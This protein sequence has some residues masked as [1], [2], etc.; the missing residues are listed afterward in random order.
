M[1][2]MD[3]FVPRAAAPEAP[4]RTG[5]RRNAEEAA[6]GGFGAILAAQDRPADLRP[7]DGA[8]Q[9]AAD[10]ENGH[11]RK[12]AAAAAAANKIT[13]KPTESAQPSAAAGAVGET[14]ETGGALAGQIALEGVETGDGVVKTGV[15]ASAAPAMGVTLAAGDAAVRTAQTAAA[16]S[17]GAPATGKPAVETT[18]QT[19]LKGETPLA[20]AQQAVAI[21]STDADAEAPAGGDGGAR[22]AP[23]TLANVTLAAPAGERKPAAAPTP[24]PAVTLEAA[25]TD[26]PASAPKLS[27]DVNAAAVETSR[28]EIQEPAAANG[29]EA[30]AATAAATVSETAS[31]EAAAVA[32]EDPAGDAE[33]VVENRA[34][35]RAAQDF[36]LNIPAA[37]RALRKAAATVASGEGAAADGGVQDPILRQAGFTMRATGA[38]GATPEASAAAQVRRHVAAQIAR[39]LDGVQGAQK[40]TI[41]LNPESLGQVDV[42]FR[43]EDDRL[44]VVLQASGV[45]AEQAIRENLKDLTDRIVDRSSRFQHVD[46]RVE[47]RDGGGDGKSDARQ[48]QR[49]DGRGDRQADRDHEQGGQDQHGDGRHGAGHDHAGRRPQ[50]AAAWARTWAGYEQED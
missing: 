17:E 40:L 42:H 33:P 36:T 31:V 10:A 47:V 22:R 21:E 37:I 2:A 34:P 9:P 5:Q 46:V 39:A 28:Q 50:A 38:E 30:P 4:A 41:R 24:A 25:G 15:A 44:T 14:T 20:A 1:Q 29:A 8:G 43:A 3:L 6:S 18:P 49:Q 26:Q 19:A 23:V 11:Q 16:A 48:D 13:D 12:P 32:A 35:Q 7:R 45:E 27:L